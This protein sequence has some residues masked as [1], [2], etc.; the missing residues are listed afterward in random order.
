[1]RTKVL[2]GLAVA[3]MLIVS[4]ATIGS[5]MGFKISIPLAQGVP[6]FVSLPY[7]V[8]LNGHSSPTA[9]DLV[10]DVTAGGGSSVEVYNWNGT[11][12]DYY[13]DGGIGQVDFAIAPGKGYQVSSA[14]AVPGWIVVGSHNPSQTI[15]ISGVPVIAAIPY[16]TTATDAA[17]L[18]T[19]LTSAG[20]TSVELYNWNGT[21]W[22]YYADGGIGQVN[23][24]LTPGV[25]IQISAANSKSW[26]PAHY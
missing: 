4:V 2:L 15:A 10:A 25:A 7:Y 17:S 19:Q 12:W 23:F 24:T 14:V 8:S 9:S 18:A 3:V 6:K 26:T 11:D 1:M 16:H 21:D 5:N 13:A 22:D 20:L